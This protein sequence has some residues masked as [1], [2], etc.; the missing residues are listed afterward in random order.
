MFN[1]YSK[2][3][4]PIVGESWK[5]ANNDE[6]IKLITDCIQ[7]N[8]KFKNI[9]PGRTTD[10]GQVYIEL[11]NSIPANLR[12]MLILDFEEYLKIKIDDGINV[13]CEPIG[14][15]NSLRKLRGVLMKS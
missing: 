8:D 1:D 11:K 7:K 6:R 15:K 10:S 5:K 14:D 2:V 12:G 4:T 9:I 13:W 3:D